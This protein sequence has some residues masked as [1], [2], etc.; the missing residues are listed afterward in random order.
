MYNRYI[1]NGANYTRILEED[2][3]PQH[4]ASSPNHGYSHSENR[5]KNS[6]QTHQSPQPHQ[7]QHAAPS[8]HTPPPTLPLGGALEGVSGLLSDLLKRFDLGGLDTGDIL[9]LL[10][11]LFI[12]MEGD[13]IEMVIVMGLM[14]LFSLGDKDKKDHP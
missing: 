2:V 9:L 4:H 12:F 6:N 13:D 3:P 1:P 11:I 10:I 8:S 14:L 5:E 7:P